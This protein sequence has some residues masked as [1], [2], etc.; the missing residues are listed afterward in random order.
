MQGLGLPFLPSCWC[1][2]PSSKLLEICFCQGPSP[3][4]I[5]NFIPL[6]SGIPSQIN[7]SSVPSSMFSQYSLLLLSI[8]GALWAQD[9]RHTLILSVSF[10]FAYKLEPL[11][12]L[13]NLSVDSF[14]Q[15]GEA[16][17]AEMR[18]CWEF[19]FLRS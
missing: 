4:C 12:S 17:L 19:L 13:W 14:T 10:A 15:S 2:S 11:E 18:A 7:V 1:Q 3:T 9:I 16:F 8:L 6:Y 5:W